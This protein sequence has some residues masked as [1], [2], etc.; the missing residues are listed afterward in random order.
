MKSLN[1]AVLIC[2]LNILNFI[3]NSLEVGEK[4]ILYMEYNIFAHDQYYTLTDGNDIYFSI[5]D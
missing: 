1:S 3:K 5:C 2:P 4:K